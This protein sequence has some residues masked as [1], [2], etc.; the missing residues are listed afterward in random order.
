LSAFVVEGPRT[1]IP[2]HLRVMR[3]AAFREGRI[4]TQ[5]VEQG[6]FNG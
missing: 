5:M 3:S 1:A 4:H 6:A 2:F